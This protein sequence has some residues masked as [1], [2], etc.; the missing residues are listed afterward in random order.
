L[1]DGVGICGKLLV[2]G[3]EKGTEPVGGDS[4]GTEEEEADE[5]VKE[6]ENDD[7]LDETLVGADR[8]DVGADDKVGERDGSR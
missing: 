3:K 6:S 7:E 4:D 8:D 2:R 5:A 1:N